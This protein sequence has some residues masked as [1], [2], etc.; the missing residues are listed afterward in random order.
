MTRLAIFGQGRMG[1]LVAELAPAAGFTVVA[2]RGE[3]D[4]AT[5]ITRATMGDAE[6]AI[7]FTVSSAAAG[8]VLGCA[9]IGLPIVSGTTGWDAARPTV[10]QEVK[11]L[12]GALLW[13]PNFAIGVHHFAAVVEEAARRFLGAGFTAAI[14]ETHHAKKLD[15]PSGTAKLLAARAERASGQ[16]IPIESVRT[17]QVPGTHELTFA[18]PFERVRLM[19]EAL[20]RRVFAAG[21]LVAANFLVGKRGIFTLDHLSRAASR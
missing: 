15:A 5:P 10:E 6:V 19:H 1:Q 11:R 18:A 12:R 17:G 16:A 7:E 20:D 4:A 8:I 14:V 13:A 2:S 21:A 3:A 9:A